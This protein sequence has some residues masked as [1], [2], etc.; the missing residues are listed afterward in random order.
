MPTALRAANQQLAGPSHDSLTTNGTTALDSEMTDPVAASGSV[1][2][3]QSEK[4]IEEDSMDAFP[5]SNVQ[6]TVLEIKKLPVYGPG[7][8]EYDVSPEPDIEEEEF[9]LQKPEAKKPMYS[10]FV[11]G[12]SFPG[13]ESD[14]ADSKEA[15]AI[16]DESS[17]SIG[18]MKPEPMEEEDESSNGIEDN[19]PDEDDLDIDE[20]LEM[21]LERRKVCVFFRL[22]NPS[23]TARV[24]I[25]Q[26][27]DI[28]A[29]VYM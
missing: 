18:Q 11:K 12:D 8:V 15:E 24:K 23:V 17:V 7:T 16:P 14:L 3:Q 6:D 29:R 10:M 26:Y 28:L 25:S 22:F 2:M 19:K 21:A 1:A 9:E 20:Q 27:V 13:S 4:L 5:E